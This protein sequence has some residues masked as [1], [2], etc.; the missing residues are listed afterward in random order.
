MLYS[1]AKVTLL[2]F[3]IGKDM[4]WLSEVSYSLFKNYH[5][6]NDPA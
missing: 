1:A 2:P 5:K 6:K 3:F 4:I